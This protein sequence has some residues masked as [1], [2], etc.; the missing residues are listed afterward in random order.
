MLNELLMSTRHIEQTLTGGETE[1][2]PVLLAGR[3]EI[4]SRLDLRSCTSAADAERL[5]E[6]RACE[7]RCLAL[8]RAQ[9]EQ[10][11]SGLLAVR[12]QQQLEYAYGTG[13]QARFASV[14][15]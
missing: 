2:L 4:V 3:R 12:R 7:E 6:I 13:N 14:S 5:H 11:R 9:K 8:A 1:Q 10:A 15:G